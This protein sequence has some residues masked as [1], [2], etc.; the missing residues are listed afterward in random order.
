MSYAGINSGPPLPPQLTQVG[1]L[2]GNR[3]VNG[4]IMSIGINNIY[5]SSMIGSGV[6]DEAGGQVISAVRTPCEDSHVNPVTAQ[7]G[8]VSYSNSATAPQTLAQLTTADLGQLPSKYSTLNGQIEQSVHPQYVFI[9]TYPNNATDEHGNVCTPTEGPPPHF[10]ISTW[11]WLEQTGNQLNAAVSATS[12]LKWIPVSGI[13]QGFIG[14]G[15]CSSASYFVTL[16]G[17]LTN[18]HQLDKNGSYH[19]TPAGQKVS[20][21]TTRA[22]VCD[23]LY[24]NPSCDGIPP[25]Q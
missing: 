15:Y 5:F 25:W 19:P 13:D 23:T 11:N 16:G 3:T 8:S 24:G 22:R 1:T 7:D 10:E 2:M 4:L 18:V 21:V 12:S 6:F 14:H 20:A 9:T 17:S